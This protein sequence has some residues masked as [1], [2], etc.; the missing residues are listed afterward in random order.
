MRNKFDTTKRRLLAGAAIGAAMTPLCALAQQDEITVTAQ[1]REQSVQD[2]PFTVNAVS[3]D[4]M[5]NASVT[6]VFSLQTQVPGLDIR[7]TN[8]PSAGA[9][10]VIRGL[11]TGVFNLGFE[12]SVGTFIDGI[13]RARS[14]IVAGGDFLDLE[15]VEVLKGPQGTLFGKN[16]TAGIIHFITA[17]PDSEAFGGMLRAEY[18]NYDRLNLQGVINMPLGDKAAFRLSGLFTDDDGYIKDAVTGEG[19]AE[20]HRWMLR[21]QFLF[22]P[23]DSVSVRI[24]GDYAKAD[25]NTVT[26]VPHTVDLSDYAFNLFVAQAAGSD[27]FGDSSDDKRRAAINT[28]P[29]LNAEDWG[30]SGEINIDL[31]GSNITSITS[32]RE[33]SDT[34]SADN[35]FVGT[36]V[37]NTNQ[38]ESIQTFTQELRFS[39]QLGESIDFMLGGFY[40][41]EEITRLNEFVWGSQIGLSGVG[42]FFPWVPGVAFTDNMGQDAQNYGVFA[43]AITDVGSNWTLTTGLRYSWDKKDGFGTFTAPQSFPLPVVYDYGA[44]TA[45]PASVDDSGLSATASLGYAVSDDVDV[46]WTYSRGYKGGGVSLIRDAG[47]VFVGPAFG[48]TPPGCGAGPFPGT[49]TCT[50]SDPTFEKE[51]TNHFEMGVKTRFLD[52]RGRLNAAFFHTRTKNLQTQS[53]LPS[54]T[55]DVINIGSA[56]SLGFDVE[57]GYELFDGFNVDGGFVYAETED[58][59]GNTLDHAPRWSGVIGATYEHDLGGGLS[60]F[61]HADASFKDEYKTQSATT[62]FFE[63]G[64]GLLNARA[65]I[66]G[67]DG[68]WELSGWCRNC[69]DKDYRTIDFI[70]PLDGAGFNFDGASVLSYIGEPRYYGVTVQVKY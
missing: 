63:D 43:H 45:I 30:V 11:G 7:T 55:F 29:L 27:F 60:G 49:I 5:A 48:P 57:F 8:P 24:I 4:A 20:K 9:S 31:G 14:G 51:T 54:G 36:D 2:V 28:P 35:D 70:I 39:T 56:T 52:G 6:D 22:E 17:K 47:G 15:R 16:T 67:G 44:G 68:R 58:N 1:R 64:Y 34:L 32:Y 41:D 46:Y 40:S 69:L 3:A 38:G 26:A 12:P 50:P 53:L 10:F 62:P 19:Y 59:L 42:F 61:A 21:G 23:S 33:F 13:Y 37:L 25:E 66:R 18:G 65:G